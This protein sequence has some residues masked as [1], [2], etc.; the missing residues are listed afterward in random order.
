MRKTIP[1]ILGSSAIGFAAGVLIAFR[2]SGRVTIQTVEA[3]EATRRI[4]GRKDH[5][6]YAP[7]SPRAVPDN[8]A[9]A[10]DAAGEFHYRR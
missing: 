9:T 3:L 4:D 5:P 1:T 2:N 10:A 6:S 8:L 7:G